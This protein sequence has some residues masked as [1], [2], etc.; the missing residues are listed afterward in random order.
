MEKNIAHEWHMNMFSDFCPIIL[1]P[2]P[3]RSEQMRLMLLWICIPL[4]LSAQKKEYDVHYFGYH[5]GISD[6]A[7]NAICHEQNGAVWLGTERGLFRWD[8]YELLDFSQQ[9]MLPNAANL[10]VCA[11]LED[12]Y[13]CLWVATESGLFRLSPDRSQCEPLLDVSTRALV[14]D[15]E[16]NLLAFCKISPQQNA[17][18]RFR[19]QTN[20]LSKPDT[21]TVPGGMPTHLFPMPEGGGWLV[22]N[23]QGRMHLW[24]HG[25]FSEASFEGMSGTLEDYQYSMQRERFGKKALAA[26][27]QDFEFYQHFLHLASGKTCLFVRGIQIAIFREND[28]FRQ[29][30]IKFMPA[31]TAQWTE[32]FDLQAHF[33]RFAGA[34]AGIFPKEKRSLIGTPICAEADRYGNLW[35]GQRVGVFILS[36]KQSGLRHLPH[37]LGKSMRA[38]RMDKN[39]LWTATVED[40]LFLQKTPDGPPEHFRAEASIRAIFPLEGQRYLIG[41]DFY[42][43]YVLDTKTKRKQKL[44]LPHDG[45]SYSGI[46]DG[47]F[48]W[49]VRHGLLRFD[50]RTKQ[51]Q[52]FALNLSFD[53]CKSIQRPPDGSLLLS[54]DNGLFRVPISPDGTPKAPQTL[55]EKTEFPTSLL[56]GDTLWLGTGGHGLWYFDM[57]TQRILAKYT[58]AD[59][60]PDNYINCILHDPVKGQIWFSTNRGLCRFDPKTRQFLN[61]G[62]ADGLLNVEYN[63]SSAW[64]DPATGTMYFGGLNGVTYFNPAEINKSSEPAAVFLSKIVRPSAD[65]GG[66]FEVQYPDME[67]LENFVLDLAPSDRFVEFHLASTDMTTPDQ[68]RFFYKLDGFDNDWVPAGKNPMARFTNLPAGDFVFRFKTANRDGRVSAERTLRLH[69]RQFFYQTFW[70]KLLVSCVVFGLIFGYFRLKLTQVRQIHRERKRIADDLHDDVAAT[71][72]QLSMLAKSLA[73]SPGTPEELPVALQ[74]IG[75]L[76]DESLGKLADIVWAVDDRRQTLGDLANRLQDQAEMSLQPL[77]IRLRATF[78]MAHPERNLK[79]AVR[80]HV[81]LIFKEALHNIVRHT[82]S[83]VVFLHL[84]NQGRG[85]TVV[86][87]NEFSALRQGVRSSGKGLESMA[88]RALQMGGQFDVDK[89]ETTFRVRFWVPD[90]FE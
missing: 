48:L 25:R 4:L 51:H 44:D 56:V 10:N 45:F 13:R 37:T 41:G 75:S 65:S 63:S 34:N 70:F 33:I 20:A 84:E 9:F 67:D 3:R 55:I 28:H 1:S 72:S 88:G 54:T 73:S 24:R 77:R 18:F 53:A 2:L 21:L 27:P 87:E 43:L 29:Y 60:L 32:P 23:P 35:C 30:R 86:I 52:L 82:E 19:P 8:G 31:D 57:R 14:M 39:G 16:K 46:S 11:L 64:R 6:R 83:Q 17:L 5:E 78:E 61:F 66:Q 69:V 40:D 59:G 38:I 47:R 22:Q 26:K 90:I 85:M 79:S 80:Q 58:T 36:P 89:T 62:K 12:Q 71:V 42:E 49:F 7:V 76:S 50:P 15:D 74:K 68:N 81:M